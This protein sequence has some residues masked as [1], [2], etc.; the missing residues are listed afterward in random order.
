M[1]DTLFMDI[2]VM[3][4]ISLSG[5][6][7]LLLSFAVDDNGCLGLMGDGICSLNEKRKFEDGLFESD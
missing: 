2:L 1:D 4:S 7:D 3:N 5:E 6:G